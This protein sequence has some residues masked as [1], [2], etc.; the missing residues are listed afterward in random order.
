LNDHHPDWNNLASS[1]AK[2]LRQ[3]ALDIL[4]ALDLAETKGADNLYEALRKAGVGG[5]EQHLYEIV[6]CLDQL[7][8]ASGLPVPTTAHPKGQS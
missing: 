5:P 3:V 4:T 2:G 1:A 7:A 6:S 8:A